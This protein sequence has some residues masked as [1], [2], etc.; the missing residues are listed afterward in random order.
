MSSDRMVDAWNINNYV[1][2]KNTLKRTNNGLERHNKL[3]KSLFDIGT[4]YFARFV[5]IMREESEA[6]QKIADYMNQLVVKRKKN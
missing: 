3:M 1:G 6:Q 4:P 5:N 2:N